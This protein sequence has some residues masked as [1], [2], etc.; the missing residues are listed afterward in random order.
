VEGAV[1]HL[2]AFGVRDAENFQR[3]VLGG[4]G[5]GKIAGIGQ[6]FPGFDDAVDLV[7]GGFILVF[8]A[9]FRN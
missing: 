2:V 1:L 8:R 6:Q 3:L 5:E 7:F 9:V 4:G